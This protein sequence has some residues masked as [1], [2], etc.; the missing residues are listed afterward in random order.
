[1]IDLEGRI[2]R[3]IS[4]LGGATTAGVHAHADDLLFQTVFEWNPLANRRKVH[5]IW[6]DFVNFAAA[7]QT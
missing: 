7:L 5:S 2:K 6:M 1:M 4:R 3:L